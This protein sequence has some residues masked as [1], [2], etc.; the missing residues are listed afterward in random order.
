VREQR[1]GRCQERTPET[2]D[3]KVDRRHA[4]SLIYPFAVWRRARSPAKMIS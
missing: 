1:R 4:P 3:A 2:D